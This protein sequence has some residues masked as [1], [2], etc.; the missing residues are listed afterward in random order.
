MTQTNTPKPGPR[1]DR[2]PSI[3]QGS[4][5]D[6]AAEAGTGPGGGSPADAADVAVTGDVAPAGDISVVTVSDAQDRTSAGSLPAVGGVVQQGT[7]TSAMPVVTASPGVTASDIDEL[8]ATEAA[9]AGTEPADALGGATAAEPA[10]EPA[11]ITEDAKDLPGRR[12]RPEGPEPAAALTADRLLTRAAAAPVSGWRRWLY[13]ATLGY[14]NLGDSDQVRIQRAMEHRIAM[15][16]G[17]RTRYVPVLSRKGGVGKTTVTT[18]LGMVLAE[19]REDRVIAMDANPDRGTLS[20]RSPG[21]A[22]FTARQ[23]VKDRFTVDSFAQLSNYTARDGSRLDVLASDTDPMVAHAFDDAD[24][25][26][27]TDILGRYYSIVLTDSGTGMVHSVM[28]GTLEKADAVVLVS[29]GSVDEARLA[30]ETL[31]WLEAHG[32]QD[33]VAKATVVINM[34]AGNRTLVNIDEIEQHFLSRVKN[35]VRIPHDRHLAEG[36]RIRLGQLKP[37]TRAA[38]VEL[39]ALVVDEL[40]QA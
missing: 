18:L 36:S 9:A 35:V 3:S 13:Q 39:A 30:S 34:A 19:L 1:P 28:K 22:D 8:S 16:L 24:Y 15:R 10:S 29:G 6:V 26:A 4:V 2:R 40:Q 11:A 17:E 14:V 20:D 33:L 38:A 32:R 25:R 31:S 27:V 5:V 37:A 21:R 12:E 23:L 7:V